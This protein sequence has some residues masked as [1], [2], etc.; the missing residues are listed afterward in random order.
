MLL[1]N[2]LLFCT[3]DL[4]LTWLLVGCWGGGRSKGT[5]PQQLRAVGAHGDGTWSPLSTSVGPVK[6][7]FVQGGPT[8]AVSHKLG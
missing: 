3:E 1:L 2:L 8:S 7:A 5:T 4:S 6:T